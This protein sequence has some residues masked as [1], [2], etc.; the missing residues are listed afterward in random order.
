MK[1]FLTM[2]MSVILSGMV[3]ESCQESGARGIDPSPEKGIVSGQVTD[4]RGNPLKN[5]SIELS[6]TVWSDKKL[7]GKTDE[8]GSYSIT[9]PAE[10][11]GNWTI[12]ARHNTIAYGQQYQFILDANDNS[13]VGGARGAIRNFTWKLSGEHIGGFYG[14]AVNVYNLAGGIPLGEVKLIFSTTEESLVDGTEARSMEKIL[15]NVHGNY[16]AAFIPIGKYMVQ[17]VYQGKPLR[18]STDKNNRAAGES[19]EVVFRPGETLRGAAFHAELFVT[20]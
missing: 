16:R 19:V 5:V 10:P 7:T 13:S 11:R 4:A 8:D 20:K 15:E 3:A 14:G 12:Q 17:A 6:H 1:R 9:L 18:L 2:M